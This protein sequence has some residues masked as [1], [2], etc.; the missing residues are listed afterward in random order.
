MI[1]GPVPAMALPGSRFTSSICA[2]CWRRSA[3]LG[4]DEV[5][6]TYDSW[7]AGHG[8]VIVP[9]PAVTSWRVDAS[10]ALCCCGTAQLT[11]RTAD[12]QEAGAPLRFK[13]ADAIAAASRQASAAAV[14]DPLALPLRRFEVGRLCLPGCRV[15]W[16]RWALGPAADVAYASSD[17]PALACGC[18]TRVTHGGV[19]LG[20]VKGAVSYRPT[21]ACGCRAGPTG[22]L[23]CA[24]SV[25]LHLA[26]RGTL[27]GY[28]PGGVSDALVD[29]VHGRRRTAGAGPGAGPEVDVRTVRGTTL[30]GCDAERELRVTT[31]R[32]MLKEPVQSQ[33]AAALTCGL[34]QGVTETSIRVEDVQLVAARMEGCRSRMTA[35]CLG[36]TRALAAALAGCV[37]SPITFVLSCACLSLPVYLARCLLAPVAAF[38]AA[39]L[40]CCCFCCGRRAHVVVA[41]PLDLSLS[42]RPRPDTGE[43]DAHGVASSLSATVRDLQARARRRAFD[44]DGAA[45]SGKGGPPPP[46]PPPPQSSVPAYYPAPVPAA[47]GL[48]SFGAPPLLAP[49]GVSNTGAAGDYAGS[50]QNSAPLLGGASGAAPA[51]S[52]DFKWKKPR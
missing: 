37:A 15:G 40:S 25:T 50:Y 39:V 5:V 31:D 42:L 44:A 49:Y 22:A 8:R 17:W 19:R 26:D 35:A 1:P 7:C 11:V 48:P 33:I 30:C 2:D 10:R 51:S 18:G 12:G 29:E 20:E 34:C 52:A 21:G 16:A 9:T 47:A 6:V 38:L 46:P 4:R 41:G 43:G 27:E 14:A 36:S 28:A 13:D 3:D 23:S 24:E 32:V 45:G